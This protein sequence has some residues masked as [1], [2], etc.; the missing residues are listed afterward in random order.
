MWCKSVNE[1]KIY[2][3]QHISPQKVLYIDEI[4]LDHDSGIYH[5]RG[6]DYIEFLNW[7]EKKNIECGWTVPTIF[8]L[9]SMNPVGVA[10]MRRI[11]ERN[12]WKE[13]K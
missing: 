5:Y 7:L 11:I 9:H 1:A 2:C 13:I 8:F 3:C 12:G 10:N 6:G 4:S